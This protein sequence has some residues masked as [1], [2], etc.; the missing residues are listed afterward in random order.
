MK[1]FWILLL[2]LAIP[3]GLSNAYKGTMTTTDWIEVWS[4]ARQLDP[5]LVR[6]IIKVESQG[7]VTAKSHKGAIGL[8][9]IM[10][11]HG[12]AYGITQ[13]KELYIPNVNIMIG[14]KYLK[15]VISKYG[16]KGGLQAYVLGETKY[17][18]GVRAPSYVRKVMKAYSM[19]T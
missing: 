18:R 12:R 2:I 5:R 19:E 4:E 15:S 9:Q 7:K 8:M 13:T 17:Y 3:T 10:P 14:T 16:V 6:A 11:I 1:W